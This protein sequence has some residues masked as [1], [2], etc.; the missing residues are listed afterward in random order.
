MVDAIEKC[1]ICG[2]YFIEAVLQKVRVPDQGG[3]VLKPV[4]KTC[5]ENVESRSMPVNKEAKNILG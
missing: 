1:Y 3:Y 2:N 5:I 4:C